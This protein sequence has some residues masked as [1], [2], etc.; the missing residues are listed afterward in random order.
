[1]SPRIASLHHV[2][3]GFEWPTEAVTAW[4]QAAPPLLLRSLG[5]LVAAA[6]IFVVSR[7]VL[8]R[9]VKRI[10]SRTVTEVD[11]CV[12]R[13]LQKALGLSS[14]FW[15]VWRIV[16]VW[17]GGDDPIAGPHWIS[18]FVLGGW[19]VALCVPASTFVSELLKIVEKT[20]APR[21]K[22]ELDDT[23]LPLANTF[24]K[25][26]VIVVG[27][28]MALPVMGV[29]VAPL[30]GGAG[31]AGLAISFAAKDTLSNFIAGILLIIDRPFQ[32]GDRIELWNAPANSGTWGD[33]VEIGLRAIK[34]KNPDN[35]IVIVPNSQVMQRDII[36]YTTSGEDIRLRIP[37]GIG[38][39][40]D[41]EL[42]KKLI[43]E[44]AHGIEGIQAHPA[45]VVI[46]RSFDESSVGLEA[47]VW[48][49]EARKRRAIGDELT[50]RVKVAFDKHDIEIPFPKRDLYIR[51]LPTGLLHADEAPQ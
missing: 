21:T 13:L 40:A 38:Y 36:N 42:A 11:D 37:I 45:P 15:A 17:T 2:D 33:V 22:T 4:L 39:D 32:I 6:L 41:T 43:L 8:S 20:I 35:I 51:S 29:S 48:I 30:L 16:V 50:D 10:T 18:K 24:A 34:V 12:V 47:R 14:L 46:T 44:A 25:F 9:I 28:L 1:M 27:V 3:L 7:W 19:I 31:I 5:V 26:L 49:K 23:I